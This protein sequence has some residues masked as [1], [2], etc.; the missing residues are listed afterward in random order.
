MAGVHAQQNTKILPVK[1]AVN[2][3]NS[4]RR[5][6]D[7]SADTRT[8]RATGPSYRGTATPFITE[9]FSSGSS[10][11]LPTGWSA[12]NS[13]TSPVKWHWT[14]VRA[15]GAYSIPAINSTTA[16]NGW[17]IFDS[18]SAG[19]SAGYAPPLRAF[20]QSSAYSCTGHPTVELT[21]QQYFRRFQDTCAV[22][23]S[24]DGGLTWVHYPLNV[25]NN[26][27][28]TTYLPTNPHTARV[29]ITATAGNQANVRI[30]FNYVTTSADGSYNWMVDDMGLA[31][32][33]AV[34]LGLTKSGMLYASPEQTYNQLSAFSEMPAQLVDSVFPFSFINNFGV[35]GGTNVPVVATITRSG[36][37]VYN[38]TITYPSLPSGSEDS[39]VQLI[40]GAGFFPGTVGNYTSLFSV[41]QPGDAVVNNNTDTFRFAVT[42][43]VFS[44]SRSI[45]SG[46]SFLHR[47]ATDPLGEE[48]N[49]YGSRF[50]IPVGK[51]DTLTSISASFNSRTTPG[52]AVKASIYKLDMS[53]TSWEYLTETPIKTLTVADISR[54]D[55]ARLTN[56]LIDATPGNPLILGE[57]VYAAVVQAV[58]VADTATVLVNT[59]NALFDETNLT[60][61]YGQSS[62]ASA[63]GIKPFAD[64]VQIATG[65]A[66]PARMTLNFGR[67]RSLGISNNIPNVTVSQIYPN[68]ADASVTVRLTANTAVKGTV[69]LSN[70]VG[71]VMATTEISQQ[72]ATINTAALPNGMYFVTIAAGDNRVVRKVII[73]H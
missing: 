12:Y 68:P 59:T 46:S 31:D 71:Q 8:Y 28:G 44:T 21:F 50:D 60:S 40:S 22:D 16:S 24:N 69:S 37:S 27:A 57:G 42:D 10:A 43:T 20:L 52:V 62:D 48:Y 64:G 39:L 5:V 13:T 66:N 4:S 15:S 35:N 6:S 72:A 56:F 53:I 29:N 9:N 73:S 1:G 55:S 26:L 38:T 36:A 70:A 32:M 61:F 7:I 14:N 18:D 33:E 41:N 23:V 49:Y 17:M 51:S 3:F 30:R 54:P 2:V 19:A 63:D 47:P 58:D 45:V 67:M 11:G 25:N 65:L 34:D